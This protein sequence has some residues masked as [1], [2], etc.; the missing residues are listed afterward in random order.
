MIVAN[1]MNFGYVFAFFSFEKIKTSQ[2]CGQWPMSM[3]DMATS[4]WAKG[5]FGQWPVGQ[6]NMATNWAEGRFSQWPI[7]LINMVTNWMWLPAE[8]EKHFGISLG[9][10]TG[11][12]FKRWPTSLIDKV[13]RQGWQCS[14]QTR[15]WLTQF[16][17]GQEVILTLTCV[18]GW[19]CY[20]MGKWKVLAFVLE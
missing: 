5:K 15:I 4:C 20:Q 17:S 10:W 11:P 7:E 18:L 3:T 14:I 2:N 19:H 12:T 1:F 13:T 16:P 8:Q 9:I 6:A